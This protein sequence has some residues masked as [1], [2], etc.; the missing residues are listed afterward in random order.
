VDV[1]I[2]VLTGDA[3]VQLAALVAIGDQAMFSVP[4]TPQVEVVQEPVDT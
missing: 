1:G 2:E 3:P 4:C